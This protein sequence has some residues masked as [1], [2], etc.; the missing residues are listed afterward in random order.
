[1]LSKILI[2]KSKFSNSKA[3][4]STFFHSSRKL[5]LGLTIHSNL[6]RLSSAQS[7]EKIN[8]IHGINLPTSFKGRTN[9][10]VINSWSSVRIQPDINLNR[11][12]NLLRLDLQNNDIDFF[13]RKYTDVST[14]TKLKENRN[15]AWKPDDKASFATATFTWCRACESF[16]E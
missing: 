13:N 7:G 12:R 8:I 3:P 1:M 2:Y 10:T 14:Q 9:I 4:N 6:H 15:L 16:I 5:Y 11:F